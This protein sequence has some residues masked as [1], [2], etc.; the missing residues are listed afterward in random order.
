M[1]CNSKQILYTAVL[2]IK[3][4]YQGTWDKQT[5]TCNICIFGIQPYTE[6]CHG[7]ENKKNSLW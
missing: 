2:Y 7:F 4:Y 1:V 5:I 3:I 6:L